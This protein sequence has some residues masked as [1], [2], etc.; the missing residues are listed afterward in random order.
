M[1]TR[2]GLH[3]RHD[4]VRWTEV[5]N[6]SGEDI[7][8]Y[9]AMRITEYLLD[10][11]VQLYKVKKPNSDT[12]QAIVFNGPY[13]IPQNGNNLDNGRGECQGNDRFTARFKP[14]SD[15]GSTPANGEYFS[16]VP[17]QWYLEKIERADY[18]CIGGVEEDNEISVAQFQ[19]PLMFGVLLGKTTGEVT[20][21]Q[22]GTV[23]LYEGT[24]G[25]ESAT[26]RT[27]TN[28]YCRTQTVHPTEF[29]Y[30][31]QV[32]GKWEMNLAECESTSASA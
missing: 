27:L 19:F 25:S 1:T 31:F 10:D 11:V 15:G 9:A 8:P 28:V 13:T 14:T 29:V 20:Q 30:V 32:N 22:F 5:D 6:D 3:S 17:D 16:I 2:D 4:Y 7:P 23:T 12:A 21:G 18:V 26:S 24:Q